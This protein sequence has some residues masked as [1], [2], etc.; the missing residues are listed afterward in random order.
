VG[1]KN[2]VSFWRSTFFSK[3]FSISGSSIK[4]GQ[5]LRFVFHVSGLGCLGA[6]LFLQA[7][8]FTRILQHGYFKGVEQNSFILTS[9]I[10]LT[11]FAI[12]Y[13]VY[14]FLNFV[15]SIGDSSS[16]SSQSNE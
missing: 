6:A 10:F 2:S 13:F 12:A 1:K 4:R 5:V 14:M 15:F 9:E 11:G 3:F 7:L 8:V 16:R